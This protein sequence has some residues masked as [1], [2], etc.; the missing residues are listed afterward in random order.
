VK[1]VAHHVTRPQAGTARRASSATCLLM[2]AGRYA[3]L[4]Q[5]HLQT[6]D[7]A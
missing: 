6:L 5:G 4:L 7:G 2:A 1:A 3:A